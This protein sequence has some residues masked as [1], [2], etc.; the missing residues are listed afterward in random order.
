MTESIDYKATLNLPQTEFPMRA[1]LAQREPAMLQKWQQQG[2][3]KQIREAR[4]G[5]EKYILHDGPPYANGDIHLGHAVNKTLKDIIVKAKTLSGFD[6][7]YIP[8]WDCHGLPIEHNVEKKIGKAGAKV[9]YSVFRQKCRDYAMRQVEGQRKDFVRLGILGDWENPY[10]TMNFGVEADI[11]RAIGKIAKNGHLVKGYKPVYWSVVGGSALAEAEVEYQDK[12][13]FSID[14][15]Y[16]VSDKK[17]IEHLNKAFDGSL[18]KGPVSVLI[19]TTTPWTIPSSQAISVGAEVEYQLVQCGSGADQ[20]QLICASDLMESVM[21]R[22]EIS[23]YQVLASCL[24]SALENLVAQHPF[25]AREIPLL[26]GE[27]VTTDAGTGCVHTAPDHGMEDFAVAKKYGIGTLNYVLGNG[28]FKEDVDLFA[29]EHV[30]KV[31]E[32]VIDV[33]REAGRLIGCG[34]ITHSYAHC[35]RTK[36]PLIYR[37]TPQWFISMEQN[38]LLEDALAAVKTVSWHP[39]WG[40]AR[41]EG[42]L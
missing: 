30:Y 10:L 25:Y 20:F 39:D 40:Q 13:S 19:W 26:L 11:I 28:T 12:T 18:G 7:P 35:W 42:M 6:A 23:D 3:Y 32:H 38:S 24:G 22:A 21:E 1:N 34:K 8:G 5:R 2:L 29:G 33:L 4:A 16:P 36:T 27:H 17:Q 14:V 31:D 41:I 37:A 15:A 9:E